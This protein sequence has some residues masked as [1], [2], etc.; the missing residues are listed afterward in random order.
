MSRSLKKDLYINVKLEKKCEENKKS[1][2]KVAIYVRGKRSY[3][4]T[5]L[6]VG[7]TFMIYRGGAKKGS[8][9]E[10]FKRIVVTD[11]HVGKK[12]GEFSHTRKLGKHGK[13]GTH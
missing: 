6:M 12:F 11:E 5:P 3:I 10:M 4:I 7:N 9:A 13:A 8:K 2:K 1:G